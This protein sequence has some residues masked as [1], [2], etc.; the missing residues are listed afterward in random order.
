MDI[1]LASQSP[2]RR[3]LLERMGIEDFRIVVS[4]ADETADPALS[5]IAL[6][7]PALPCA[8]ARLF[9]PSRKA[10]S[11]YETFTSVAAA[12]C[13]LHRN[14]LLQDKVMSNP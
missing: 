6:P 4:D 10:P 7:F 1:I 9:P 11:F 2:R 12:G 3:E 14:W 8:S 13:V 5:P